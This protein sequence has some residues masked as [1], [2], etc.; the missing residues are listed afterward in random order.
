SGAAG[1]GAGSA[2][3][4]SGGSLRRL[5]PTLGGGI[6]HTA[7]AVIL[8]GLIGSSMYVTEVTGY[9]PYDEATDT[10]SEPFKIKDYELFYTGNEITPSE[11][12]DDI[13]YTLHYDV[14]KDGAYVGS[15]SPAVQVVQSTRQQ[16]LVASVISFPTEDLFVVYRGVNANGDFSMDVRV[17]P[18]IGFVWVGF[19]LLMAGAVVA[20]LGK[21]RS[22]SAGRAGVAGRAEAAEPADAAEAAEA[23]R[24]SA[25]PSTSDAGEALAEGARDAR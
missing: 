9:V 5:L 11:N 3:A 2:G 22:A 10:A 14:L 15:V 8:V 6:A 17:N 23:G 12:G 19:G 24:A 20:L 18:L 21:R 25:G 7:M 13:L 1:V 4:G 16:K